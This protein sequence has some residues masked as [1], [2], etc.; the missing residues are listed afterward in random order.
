[1][2]Y[3]D[4][5]KIGVQLELVAIYTPYIIKCGMFNFIIDEELIPGKGMLLEFYHVIED[6]KDNLNIGLAKKIPDIGPIPLE[7]LDFS[8]GEPKNIIYLGAGHLYDVGCCFWLGFDRDEDRF[9]YTTDYEKTIREKRYPRG[10]IEKLI[11]RLPAIDE[12]E[13]HSKSTIRIFTHLVFVTDKKYQITMPEVK[14]SRYGTLDEFGNEWLDYPHGDNPE[15]P[16]WQVMLSP[17]WQKKFAWPSRELAFPKVPLAIMPP[18]AAR[19]INF[20]H[21]VKIVEGKNSTEEYKKYQGRKG[22]VLGISQEKGIVYGYGIY[23]RD[24][25]MDEFLTFEADEVTPTGFCFKQEEFY[26]GSY[27]CVVPHYGCSI[28]DLYVAGAQ[29]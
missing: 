21:E 16:E 24:G 6:L 4:P 2:I 27:A 7:Q 10:T 3:G 8:E 13:F 1:M 9:F 22:V 5:Y 26:D 28:S 25:T 17:K 29:K 19:R 20:Y 14:G 18:A 23:F 12:I 15:D 11:L